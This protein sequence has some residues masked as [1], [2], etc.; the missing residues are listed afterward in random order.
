M[1]SLFENY[2]MRLLIIEDNREISTVLRFFI[3]SIVGDDCLTVRVVA[4][5]AEAREARR[6]F[7]PDI[8]FFDIALPDGSGFEIVREWQQDL[9]SPLI[10]MSAHPAEHYV[11]ELLSVRVFAFLPKPFDRDDVVKPLG[12]ALAVVSQEQQRRLIIEK[13]LEQY[14]EAHS[15]L[16]E[17][18]REIERLARAQS[19]TDGT[20]QLSLRSNGARHTVA[21]L[22][23]EILYAEARS[24]KVM[25]MQRKG[26][27]LEFTGTLKALEEQLG[28]TDF[29]RCHASYL[30][31]CRAVTA[32]S[33]F[34]LTLGST[35]VPISQSRAK[36]VR[37]RMQKI[38][39]KK[40]S[41]NEKNR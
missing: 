35:Q 10:C 6:T 27:A 3:R 13:L 25:V 20:L 39:G 16:R 1:R 40:P 37:E 7:E 41:K 23:E 11:S 24:N 32:Y 2:P 5:L 21:V 30:V 34:Q 28:S 36:N 9:S 14:D 17:K 38:F 33:S 26:E 12:E 8:V 15:L 4:S 22:P 19:S 31:N 29:L 18:E